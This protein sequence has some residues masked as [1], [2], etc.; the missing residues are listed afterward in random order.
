MKKAILLFS[1]GLDSTTVLSIM[2]NRGFEPVLLSF[3]YGQRQQ[4]ELHKAAAI[5]RDMGL[6]RRVIEIDLRSFG[7]SALTDY[8]DVPK[9][10]TEETLPK[11]VPITYVPA[12]NTIFLSYALALA[13]TM[14][15]DDIFTGMNQLDYG[16][17][18]DCRSEYVESFEEMSNISMGICGERKLKIHTPIINKSKKEIIQWGLSLG[19][20]YSKTISC[21]DPDEEFNSC[22][23]CLSCYHR[24]KAFSEIGVEDPI[25][26]VR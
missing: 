10:F 15:I 21:Y 17:Y 7:G 26:Y 24:L 6:Q 23:K 1:G 9:G 8:I 3:N 16:N 4:V 5:A 18:P 22:G 11:G 20:D 12:R 2:K 13:Q 19:V 25:N 14:N